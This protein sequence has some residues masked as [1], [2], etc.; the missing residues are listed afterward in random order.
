MK[1]VWNDQFNVKVSSFDELL[2]DI[3]NYSSFG[4]NDLLGEAKIP[5][6]KFM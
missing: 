3:W 4:S 6:N 2:I 1:P 5:I